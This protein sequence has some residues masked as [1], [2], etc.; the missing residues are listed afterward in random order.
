LGFVLK[1]AKKDCWQSLG[2]KTTLYRV[3]GEKLLI[4]AWQRA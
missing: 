1:K 3:I 2:L 4:P